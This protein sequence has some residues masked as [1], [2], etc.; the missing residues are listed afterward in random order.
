MHTFVLQRLDFNPS[1]DETP[2]QCRSADLMKDLGFITANNA[3]H[4]SPSG[5][6]SWCSS[7]E[8]AGLFG[9]F[10]GRR[11]SPRSGFPVSRNS[12]KVDSSLKTT[13]WFT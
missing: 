5:T 11:G 4:E 9:L 3:E 12:Q 7:Q 2:L 10:V 6:L 13:D 8:A 1:L